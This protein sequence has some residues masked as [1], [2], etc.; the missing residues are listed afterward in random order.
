MKLKYYLP[1]VLRNGET[2]NLVQES[3]L[4][5]FLKFSQYTSIKCIIQCFSYLN[6]PSIVVGFYKGDR[7]SIAKKVFEGYYSNDQSLE[8]QIWKGVFNLNEEW[9]DESNVDFLIE[10]L[11]E[12]NEKPSSLFSEWQFGAYIPSF[13]SSVVIQSNELLLPCITCTNRT[14]KPDD[15]TITLELETWNVERLVWLAYLKNT[16]SS[17]SKL[18]LDMIKEV[19][20]QYRNSFF[21]IADYVEN[22]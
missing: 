1:I 16:N 13:E 9:V 8:T 12:N 14:L 3:Q 4:V 7:E 2:F 21:E 17:F 11:C 22:E 15:L 20:K 10:K 5:Y 18:P 19:I 6:Y